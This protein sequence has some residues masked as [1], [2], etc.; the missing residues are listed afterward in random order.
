MYVFCS[1]DASENNKNLFLGTGGFAPRNAPHAVIR[2]KVKG[3]VKTCLILEITSPVIGFKIRVLGYIGFRRG[4]YGVSPSP[5]K[6]FD[7]KRF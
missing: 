2:A 3:K 1:G 4:R 7:F 6:D 5:K